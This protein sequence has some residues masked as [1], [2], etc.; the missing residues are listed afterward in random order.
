M[1]TGRPRWVPGSWIS[2][3]STLLSLVC[4]ALALICSVK[5]PSEVLL[6]AVHRITVTFEDENVCGVNLM[7]ENPEMAHDF[8]SHT[9]VTRGRWG[10]GDGLTGSGVAFCFRFILFPYM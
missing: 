2:G 3:T 7:R 4:S 1:E 6:R 8:A 9:S 5:V 10:C